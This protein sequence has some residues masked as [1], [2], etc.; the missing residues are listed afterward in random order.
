LDAFDE[1]EALRARQ[2]AWRTSAAMLLALTVI[3]AGLVILT[4]SRF[5]TYFVVTNGLN[6]ILAAG[7]VSG[8]S[9]ARVLTILRAGLGILLALVTGFSQG[10]SADALVTLL[11]LGGI[12]LPL[13]GAPR[14]VK[15]YAAIA[16]FLLGLST[17][18]F[19]FF[20]QLVVVN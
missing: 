6:L 19:A 1:A 3:N 13:I 16:L 8:A 5:D 10:V 12:A 15:S 4:R 18:L 2:Y 14:Q 9:W 17:T 7:L 20:G 11:L